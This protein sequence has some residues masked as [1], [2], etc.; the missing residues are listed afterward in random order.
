M[1]RSKC[2]AVYSKLFRSQLYSRLLLI[3]ALAQVLVL[4][5]TIRVEAVIPT[6]SYHN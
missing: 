1:N 2:E 3:P 5:L 6:L 4:V